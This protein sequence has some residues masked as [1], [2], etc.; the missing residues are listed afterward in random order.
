MRLEVRLDYFGQLQ[1]ERRG[2]TCVAAHGFDKLL[3]R[4]TDGLDQGQSFRRRLDASRSDHI[5][6]DFDDCGLPNFSDHYNFLP[7]RFQ[8]RARLPQCSIIPRDIIEKLAL[9]RGR[10][11][12]CKRRFDKARAATF[13]NLCRRN[14]RM[15]RDGRMREH[16]VARRQRR[17]EIL[18]HLK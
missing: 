13:D 5:G 8:N 2:M 3:H 15:R 4:Q 12:A 10:L 1:R 6:R 17:N 18:C 7:A 9:F 14:H 11:A 16:N